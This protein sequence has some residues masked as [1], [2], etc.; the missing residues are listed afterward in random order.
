M[1]DKGKLVQ[2]DRPIPGLFASVDLAVE[3]QAAAQIKQNAGE[4]VWLASAGERNASWPGER[5][6]S[7][8][9]LRRLLGSAYRGGS[10]GRRRNRFVGARA[11]TRQR[12]ASK[13]FAGNLCMVQIAGEEWR[14]VRSSP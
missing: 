12:Q 4:A 13:C 11:C 2:I 1:N 6:G 7:C 5:P 3:A 14:G 9:A 10:P 8:T